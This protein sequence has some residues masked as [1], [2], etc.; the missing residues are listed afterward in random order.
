MPELKFVITGTAGV[1]KSTAIASISDVTPV[2]TEAE[3]TDELK[4]L[5]STTTVAFDFGE[6]ILDEDTIVR[7]YGTPGQDRFRHMWEI[8]AE[9]ALGLVIL[10]DNSRPEPLQDLAMYIENFTDLIERT[11]VVIGVTRLTEQSVVQ[12]NDYYQFIEQRGI[13]CPILETDPRDKDDMVMIMDSLMSV[14]EYT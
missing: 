1:G 10:V 13:F 12:I 11:G 4:E 5:K 3:T 7:I 6:I 9:G 8:I 2:S 14:L